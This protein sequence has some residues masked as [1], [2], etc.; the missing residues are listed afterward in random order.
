MSIMNNT[1]VI[2][3]GFDVG[4]ETTTKISPQGHCTPPRRLTSR[5]QPVI[6]SLTERRLIPLRCRPR[7]PV[8]LMG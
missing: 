1:N 2:E 6:R 3:D 4:R 8:K 7:E 5:C